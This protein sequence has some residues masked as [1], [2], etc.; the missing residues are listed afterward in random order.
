MG[1]FSQSC[2]GSDVGS[3]VL[4]A[5]EAALSD[6]GIDEL[7]M[8][9]R[10]RRVDAEDWLV[11]AEVVTAGAA[12]GFLL[13]NSRLASLVFAKASRLEAAWTSLTDTE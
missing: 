9:L 11:L 1:S 4:R 2:A 5:V 12:S 10:L 13:E 6:V 8:G 7:A 3:R